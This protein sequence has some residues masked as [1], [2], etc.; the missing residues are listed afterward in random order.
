MKQS[1]FALWLTMCTLTS[2]AQD[3]QDT[4]RCPDAE[5]SYLNRMPGFYITDCKNS[6]YNDVEFIYWVDGKANKINK[7]GKYYH[8]FYYKKESETR[9]FSGAQINQNYNDAI[10][11]VKGKVLDNK[12]TVFSASINGKEVYIQ[13]HTAENSTNTG[14][15]NIEI[16]EVEAMQQDIV[17]SME[18]SIEKDGKIA[19]YGILFDVGKSN[20]KP[21][22]AEALKQVIDYLNANPAVKIIVVGHTDNTGTYAGNITLSKARAESVKNYLINTGKIAASRLMSEGAGQYCPVSTN[23]TEEGKKL[24]RRVEIVKL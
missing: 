2:F 11:K 21:E 16:V 10:L 17:V 23:D 3:A 18:E 19:L 6:D 20:I 8:I 15:Y 4:P 14:S 22:S 7:S 1:L 13:V 5:P 9:K 24:N 12:K